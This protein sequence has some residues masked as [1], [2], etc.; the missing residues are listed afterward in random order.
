MSIPAWHEEPVGKHHDRDAFDCGED[1]LNDFLRKY[2]RKSHE[3]GGAKSF[4]AISD[5]DN[6]TILGYYSLAP[7]SFEYARTPGMIRR[8]LA[9]HDVP[10]FRLARLATSKDLQ[11]RGFGTQLL[12]LAGKR[13]LAAAKE[14]G[15]VM[16][17]IDAKNE[18]VAKWYADRGAVP[19]SDSP[20]TLM[21]HLETIEAALKAAGQL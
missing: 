6:R 19:L 21:M 8:G 17:M 1:A 2:A 20:L 18:R 14:V 10:G 13:C 4:L 5:A 9:R 12:L 16:M 15:G 3:A 7:A 11:G